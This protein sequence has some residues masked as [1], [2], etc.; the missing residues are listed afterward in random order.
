VRLV[1]TPHGWE[2][3]TYRL[4]ADRATLKR[5]NRL[6]DDAL[7]DPAAGIGNP[8]HCATC[9]RDSLSCRQLDAD[10][11]RLLQWCARIAMITDEAGW[12]SPR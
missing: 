3:Y 4:A 12:R 11:H 6:I 10:G 9:T 1:F 5:I 8:D 7:R 2:D